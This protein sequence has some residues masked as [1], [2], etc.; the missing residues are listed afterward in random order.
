[1]ML[2]LDTCMCPHTFKLQLPLSGCQKLP[3]RSDE[4]ADE[5][6]SRP[7]VWQGDR[8]NRSEWAEWAVFIICSKQLIH[9]SCWREADGL[10]KAAILQHWGAQEVV[11]VHVCSCIVICAWPYKKMN[12]MMY[13]H[14]PVCS[15]NVRWDSVFIYCYSCVWSLPTHFPLCP[16]TP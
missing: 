1:M 7:E 2:V 3:L 10:Q 15:Q 12:K 14:M 11:R 16:Q 9:R 13:G 6:S 8:N 5:S 4:L